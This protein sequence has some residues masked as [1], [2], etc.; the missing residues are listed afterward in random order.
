M[1]SSTLLSLRETSLCYLFGSHDVLFSNISQG[2]LSCYAHNFRRDGRSCVLHATKFLSQCYPLAFG[3]YPGVKLLADFVVSVASEAIGLFALFPFHLILAL[4][5]A[6]T[7]F[8]EK[9]SPVVVYFLLQT[10]VIS[11][12]TIHILYTTGLI[13]VVMLTVSAFD[14]DVWVRDIDSSPSPF[15]ISI[16]LDF[17]CPRQLKGWRGAQLTSDIPT[18]SPRLVRSPSP[19]YHGDCRPIKPLESLQP[20]H[21]IPEG[22]RTSRSSRTLSQDLIRIPNAAEQRAS[23]AVSF[24]LL[25]RFN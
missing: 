2:S 9:T 20:G 16:I 18:A 1:Q 15:P 22:E 10:F 19:P 5:I 13:V 23:I 25:G 24:E 17:L 14:G 6:T 12:S 7:E 21:M 11:S 8:K 3:C 4:I